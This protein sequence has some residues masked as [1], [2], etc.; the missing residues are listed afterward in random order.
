VLKRIRDIVC[1]RKLLCQDESIFDSHAGAEANC[2]VQ[3]C[4]ASPISATRPEILLSPRENRFKWPANDLGGT[5][6]A[7]PYRA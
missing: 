7:V 6:K 5:I 1:P 2:G 3:A 4:A